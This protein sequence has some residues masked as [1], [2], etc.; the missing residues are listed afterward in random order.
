MIQPLLATVY[1][2]ALLANLNAR[3]TL[4][5]SLG[6]TVSFSATPHDLRMEPVIVIQG[7][8]SEHRVEF[9]Q[10]II[11][12]LSSLQTVDCRARR[13]PQERRIQELQSHLIDDHGRSSLRGFLCQ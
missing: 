8:K 13:P 10:V 3:Q 2:N 9:S 1:F 12:Q 6:D 7:H 5:N 4:N 11:Y